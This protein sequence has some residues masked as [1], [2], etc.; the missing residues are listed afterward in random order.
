MSFWKVKSFSVKYT[1]KQFEK[2][3]L[4]FEQSWNI[5]PSWRLFNTI[6]IIYDVKFETLIY[7]FKDYRTIIHSLKFGTSRIITKILNNL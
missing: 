6:I 2:L 5:S 3:S 7:I 1:E 4:T